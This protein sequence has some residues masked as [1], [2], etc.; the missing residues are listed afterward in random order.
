MKFNLSARGVLCENEKV[1][2]VE[3][4]IDGETYYA[5]P[6]GSVEIGESLE[7]C[8]IREFLEET[9]ITVI[10]KKVILINEFIN[11]KPKYVAE[12]W[13]NGIHQVEIIFLLER[14][15]ESQINNISPKKDF[16]MTGIK[17]LSKSE[18]E[19][20]TCYP[21]QEIDWF[22]EKHENLNLY[23]TKTKL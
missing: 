20:L 18:L 9:E 17:W 2:F 4:K 6:G 11:Q 8:V 3:Y 23:K 15:L 14:N 22:F 10:P 19:N 7:N 5:L 21:E 1:L 16:G 13:K 12:S